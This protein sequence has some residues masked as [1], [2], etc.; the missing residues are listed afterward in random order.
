MPTRIELLAAAHRRDK[1]DCGEPELNDFLR[2]YA[3]QQAG[4]D[5][6]RTY[7]AVAGDGARI[8][9]FHAIS[10]GAIDF[11]NWPPGLQLPRYPIPVARIGRL[12]VDVSAQGMGV[13]AALLDHAL[14]LSV[15]MAERIG[16]HAVVVD[17]KHAKAAQFYTRYGFQPFADGG[18]NMFLMM[19]VIRRLQDGGP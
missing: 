16:L 5:F 13:G 4:R 17:A 18:L 1:F 10:M 15:A 12:A 7:V 14:R 9:G 8:L 3:R 19:S 2:R 11:R 6:S